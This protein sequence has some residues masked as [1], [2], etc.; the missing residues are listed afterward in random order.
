MARE[1]LWF[2]NS[3][4]GAPVLDNSAGALVSVLDACLVTGFNIKSVSAL[5][6]S[7]GTAVATC[8]S[9][10]FS[11][12]LGKGVLIEGAT[13]GALNGVK[14]IA[15]IDANTFSFDA[16]GVSDQ[17]AT[18][19][20]QAKRAPLGWLKAHAGTNKAIYKSQHPQTN[21]QSWRVNDDFTNG[22][23]A[24]AAR[25]V[26]VE[27]ATSVD[28]YSDPSPTAAA[29]ANGLH[30]QRGSN[31]ATPKAWVLVGDGRNVYFFSQSQGVN[32]FSICGVGELKGLLSGDTFDS[33]ITG[34]TTDPSSSGGTPAFM[35]P[36]FLGANPGSESFKLAR[37][38][39][40][41]LKS[42]NA[43]ALIFGPSGQVVGGASAWS[44]PSPVD[45]GAVFM[46]P[47]LVQE[48]NATNN[49]PA[50]GY[51]AG[52][53]CCLHRHLDFPAFGPLLVPLTDGSGKTVLLVNTVR[54]NGVDGNCSFILDEQW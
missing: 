20:I 13:P 38:A 2:S 40:A 44:Y 31:T 30:I 5:V 27:S 14:N 4:A 17:T 6:V 9:H 12:D 1:V 34:N 36:Q 21:G 15:V 43:L 18:G 11:A 28:A 52:L 39:S 16:T 47:V 7:G 41:L 8:A 10:G 25:H 53:V 46:G 24:T 51:A 33:W 22:S 23:T 32:A 37:S 42:V 49:H 35:S 19:T 48:A 45:N 3:D 26:L 50:R 29:V 54:F